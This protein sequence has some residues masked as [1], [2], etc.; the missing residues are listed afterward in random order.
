MSSNG[1]SYWNLLMQ[2]FLEWGASSPC[3]STCITENSTTGCTNLHSLQCVVIYSPCAF[4]GKYWESSV[5]GSGDKLLF[6]MES[7]TVAICNEIDEPQ[8][9]VLVINPDCRR[10]RALL[11]WLW[12]PAVTNNTDQFSNVDNTLFLKFRHRL[13]TS[14]L[15]SSKGLI[16]VC[17]K[18]LVSGKMLEIKWRPSW[19]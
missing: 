8:L 17:S 15:G 5:W 19:K 6:S 12:G 7:K 11:D 4:K 3:L 9:A 10:T 1:T 2:R 18:P 13:E 16:P 14:W